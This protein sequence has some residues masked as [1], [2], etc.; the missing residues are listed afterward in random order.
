MQTERGVNAEG[1][2]QRVSAVIE[3]LHKYLH[4]ESKLEGRKEREEEQREGYSRSTEGI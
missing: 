4:I 2:T 3:S 1:R